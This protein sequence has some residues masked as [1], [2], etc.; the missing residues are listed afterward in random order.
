MKLR[1]TKGDYNI[2]LDMGTNSVGWA[3]T[4]GAGQLT[5]FKGKPTWGSRL[6]DAAETA[7]SARVPRGQRRRYVRRRWRLDLLQGL[8]E[9]EMTRVDPEFFIRLSQSRLLKEDRKEGHAYY[10]W[11]LF[12]DSDFTETDYY[13]KF[14]T[15]YH[16][17]KWLMETDERADIRLI[18]L[19]CHNIVKHRGNFL[20]QD[21]RNL[22]A[23]KRQA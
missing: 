1:N 21:E 7:A 14:P 2:G 13:E 22:S 20:R 10:R 23:K 12:N 15:I 9:E 5:Y 16:L 6:F 4:D 11:P 17:R 3:V 18:Y 8:F 19:A